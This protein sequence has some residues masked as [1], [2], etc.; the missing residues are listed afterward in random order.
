MISIWQPKQ[1]DI[2]PVQL[3][4]RSMYLGLG[5][6]RDLGV[7]VKST[8]TARLPS[9]KLTYPTKREKEN[10]RLK[11]PFFWAY[12]SSLEGKI[13][14]LVGHDGLVTVQMMNFGKFLKSQV[15]CYCLSG[16]IYIYTYIYA[17][18][19]KWEIHVMKIL[20][21]DV[22]RSFLQSMFLQCLFLWSNFHQPL[23]IPKHVRL[24]VICLFSPKKHKVIIPR[25][26]RCL[27]KGSQKLCLISSYI[28]RKS[29][30]QM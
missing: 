18:R 9:R 21:S 13:Q 22:W 28:K 29:R 30:S 7:K 12:V 10:H 27:Y 24:T 25:S 3:R 8:L 26:A 6:G 4:T 23:Q 11:M 5:L 19:P 17:A 14:N 16:C 1:P 2:C 15:P 20:I